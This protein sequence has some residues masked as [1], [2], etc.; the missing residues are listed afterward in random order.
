MDRKGKSDKTTVLTSSRTQFKAKP[1][2]RGGERTRQSD[3]VCPRADLGRFIRSTGLE[4]KG[5]QPVLGA[6]THAQKGERDRQ[7][8]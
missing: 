7:M 5:A 4:H 6:V 2:Q 8:A 1:L 3:H